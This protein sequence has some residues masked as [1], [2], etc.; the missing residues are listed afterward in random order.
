MLGCRERMAGENPPQARREG[1]VCR[2][3]QEMARR[4]PAVT[5]NEVRTSQVRIQVEPRIM[6]LFALSL[7]RLRAIFLFLSRITLSGLASRATSPARGEAKS[8]P[9][10]GELAFAKQM[11]EGVIQKRSAKT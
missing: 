2:R 3:G 10:T 8:A 5:G 9:F 7:T 1:T 6:Y 11:T 4:I